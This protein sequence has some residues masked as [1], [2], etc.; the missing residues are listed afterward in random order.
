MKSALCRLLAGFSFGML[1]LALAS[2]AWPS[3]PGWGLMLCVGLAL[4]LD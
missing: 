1:I 4:D 3:V 2:E